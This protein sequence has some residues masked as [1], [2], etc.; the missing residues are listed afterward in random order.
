MSNRNKVIENC[1]IRLADGD[2][3]AL[4]ELYSTIKGDLYAYAL[5]KSIS[6][7][8]A[9]DIMQDTFM[10]IFKNARL[11]TPS[12]RPMAWIITI[13]SN[14]INRHFQLKK[15][16]INLDSDVLDS[17]ASVD[18]LGLVI[19]NR[20]VRELLD[21]LEED[22]RKII[23]LH[24]VSNMKFREIAKVLN[25]PLSTVLSRYNRAIKKLKRKRR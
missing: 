10:L 1:I 13:E 18:T 17:K 5:S 16:T 23:V 24:I 15:R 9:E 25:Q 14:L 6:K 20:M 22:E 3:S 21:T 7:L 8:D 19:E 11:Y 2:T 12:G 4:D